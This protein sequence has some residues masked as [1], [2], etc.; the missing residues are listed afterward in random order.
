MCALLGRRKGMRLMKSWVTFDNGPCSIVVD[1]FLC[2][3]ILEDAVKGELCLSLALN[4]KAKKERGVR[5]GKRVCVM[6]CV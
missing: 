1:I 5:D 2:C 3:S 6:V 4:T